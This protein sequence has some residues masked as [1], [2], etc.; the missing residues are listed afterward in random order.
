MRA[1]KVAGDQPA[2]ARGFDILAINP[3]I[4]DP[5]AAFSYLG[6]KGGSE[7]GVLNLTWL[8]RRKADHEWLFL[9]ITWNDGQNA[10]NE[11]RAVYV[12]GAAR[13]QLSTP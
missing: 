7:P 8:L 2:T 5:T 1:L 6:Y 12:A 11:D 9:S 13:A 10:I 4:P 3:G